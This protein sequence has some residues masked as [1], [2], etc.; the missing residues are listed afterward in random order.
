M[1]TKLEYKIELWL[2][3]VLSISRI[4][5]FDSLRRQNEI[6]FADLIKHPERRL[7]LI[8]LVAQTCWGSGWM[9]P[10]FAAEH[11]KMFFATGK[12]GKFCKQQQMF[13]FGLT[14]ALVEGKHGKLAGFGEKEF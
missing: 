13:A 6:H 1:E 2:I 7:R 4:F 3:P 5:P 12:M 11:L 8:N 9:L 14:S 10:K